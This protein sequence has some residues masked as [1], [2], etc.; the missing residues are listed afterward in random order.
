MRQG[1]AGTSDDMVSVGR[2]IVENLA[3]LVTVTSK[4]INQ[5]IASLRPLGG[6]DELLF[7]A[8]APTSVRQ[9][10]ITNV[11]GASATDF[12]LHHVPLGGSAN[13][14]NALYYDYPL[15]DGAT[16]L[17][18]LDIRLATGETLWV[19]SATGGNITFNVYGA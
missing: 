19:R 4:S 15:A 9:I 16:L 2:A 8:T 13:Q 14:E 3:A 6:G 1:F 18:A 5:R 11:T 7:T 12:R 10:F 17:A